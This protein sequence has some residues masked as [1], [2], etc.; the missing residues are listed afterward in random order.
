MA[1]SVLEGEREEEK[2]LFLGIAQRQV[3]GSLSR[4]TDASVLK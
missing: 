3:A 1:A 4:L 2:W